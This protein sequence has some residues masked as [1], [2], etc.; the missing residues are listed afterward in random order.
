MAGRDREAMERRRGRM[1]GKGKG[2]EGVKPA[3]NLS[4]EV[5]VAY[6]NGYCLEALGCVALMVASST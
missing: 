3:I 1:S 6:G 5:V 4:A 2:L